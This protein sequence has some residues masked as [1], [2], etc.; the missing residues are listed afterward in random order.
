MAL[1]RRSRTT[2]A[3]RARARGSLAAV[4]AARRQELGL[5]QAELAE[6]AGVARGPVVSFEA[7]RTVSLEVLTSLLQVLGLHLELTRGAV[8]DGLQVSE[9]LAAQYGLPVGVESS[10]G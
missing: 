1:Q 3:D 9:P 8:S 10:R 2:P 7:G 6:L 5:T 4:V